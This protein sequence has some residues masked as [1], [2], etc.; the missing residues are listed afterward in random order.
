MTAAVLSVHLA[1]AGSYGHF[2]DELYFMACAEHLDWGYVDQPPLIAVIAWL[3]RHLLG[4]SVFAVNVIP[5]LAGS[6]TV[7]LTGHIA[8]E[9]GGGRFAQGL[10]AL[11][12]ACA[13]TYL[14][15]GHLFTMNVFEP[16]F[17][18]GCILFVIRMISGGNMRSWTWVGLLAGVGLEN[19][20]SIAFFT[21]SSVAGLLLSPQ[22]RILANRWFWGGSLTCVCH[23]CSKPPV[24]C[25][26]QL[27]SSS[28]LVRD[29]RGLVVRRQSVNHQ[30]A[31]TTRSLSRSNLARPYIDRLMSLSR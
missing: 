11:C 30:A 9:L 23:L 12:A 22:R 10:A 31:A 29:V 17:W 16:L 26:S 28:D 25:E 18:M 13:G 19:K 3:T 27:G 7:W 2:G 1:T 14:A 8:R 20:Y 24:E 21:A 15:M 5:A 4:T 6:A